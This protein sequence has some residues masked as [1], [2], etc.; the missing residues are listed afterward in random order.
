M[1]RLVSQ[2]LVFP[3]FLAAMSACVGEASVS[4]QGSVSEGDADDH[5]FST[6]PGE[7]IPVSGA[8]VE[9]CLDQCGDPETTDAAGRYPEIEAVF[10]G[11]VGSDTQIEVR[12]TA[13]DGRQVSYTTT[14]ENT[15]DPTVANRY[16]DPPCPAIYLNFTL[17]PL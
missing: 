14:Y 13:P 17:A 10:G 11:F 6:A 5:G 4:Y 9:L 1:R 16:C 3:S 8:T 15:D 12:V 2:L 7:G